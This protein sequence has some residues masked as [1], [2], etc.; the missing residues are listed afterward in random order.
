MA[1]HPDSIGSRLL[2]QLTATRVIEPIQA[3]Y[4]GRTAA[5]FRLIR[6]VSL[7]AAADPQLVA[8]HLEA[9]RRDPALRAG[10]GEQDPA[11]TC[12]AGLTALTLDRWPDPPSTADQQSPL[13]QA[14]AG[15]TATRR[16]TA[17]QA[18]R[19][20]QPSAGWRP[21]RIEPKMLHHGLRAR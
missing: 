7:L 18:A 15:I 14:V 4:P 5:R 11:W 6:A 17:E 13:T 1:Y 12:L 10:S 9:A 8:A 2:A 21:Q 3:A 16:P 19:P 20:D